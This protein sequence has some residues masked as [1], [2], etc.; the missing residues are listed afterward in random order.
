MYIYL[1]ATFTS[2]IT[3]VIQVVSISINCIAIMMEFNNDDYKSYYKSYCKII[4]CCCMSFG[5]LS[6]IYLSIMLSQS[7]ICI[8]FQWF[9]QYFNNLH[10]KLHDNRSENY[11]TYESYKYMDCVT[12]DNILLCFMVIVW[13]I[14]SVYQLI[15]YLTFQ[16]MIL[17]YH[18]IQIII[19]LFVYQ[20]ILCHYCNKTRHMYSFIMYWFF[21]AM[22]YLIILLLNLHLLQSYHY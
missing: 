13:M 7:I 11:Q 18:F 3:I 8:L 6:M 1:T 5:D 14:Y 9:A 22:L 20:T 19:V 12:I 21:L 17:L 4:Y 15:K 2:I 10:D 16:D